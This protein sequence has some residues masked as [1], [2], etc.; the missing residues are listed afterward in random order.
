MLGLKVKRIGDHYF[1]F[2]GFNKL[3]T[4]ILPHDFG[5][6]D[7]DKIYEVCM[8]NAIATIKLDNGKELSTGYHTGYLKKYFE[9]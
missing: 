1:I 5:E 3:K 6:E 2:R 4:I 9:M 7:K 8:K